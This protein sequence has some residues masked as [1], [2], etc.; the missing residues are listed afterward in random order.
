MSEIPF[1]VDGD[2]FPS[3]KVTSE[4]V[5]RGLVAKMLRFWAKQIESD[6]GHTR[7]FQLVENLVELPRA[8]P[9]DGGFPISQ[10]RQYQLMIV[11]P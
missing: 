6:Q 9:P 7:Y 4:A 1:C 8:L 10:V 3:V 5:D 2:P 11:D